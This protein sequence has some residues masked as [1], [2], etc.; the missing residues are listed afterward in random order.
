[1]LNRR[2][3]LPIGAAGLIAGLPTFFIVCDY[4]HIEKTKFVTASF[5]AVWVTTG[6]IGGLG[7]RTALLK[8]PLITLA[9]LQFFIISFANWVAWDKGSEQD[10][11]MWA[12]CVPGAIAPLLFASKFDRQALRTFF[13]A[14]IGWGSLLAVLVLAGYVANVDLGIEV[15]RFNVA[16]A[17]NPITQSLV[18]GFAVI[19]LYAKAL[20]QGTYYILA[21]ILVMIFSMLLAGSRGPAIAIVAAMLLMTLMLQWSVR[22][23]LII[24][25]VAASVAVVITYLPQSVFGRYFSEDVWLDTKTGQGVQTRIDLYTTGL[26]TW[27]KHPVFGSGTSG[28]AHLISYTHNL[29]IQILMET[30][31]VG[32]LLFLSASL[33]LAFNFFKRSRLEAQSSWETLAFAGFLVYS[34]IESQVSG[35][36]IRLD[37]LWVCMGV[38]ISWPRIISAQNQIDIPARISPMRAVFQPSALRQMRAVIVTEKMCAK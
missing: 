32:L 6:I 4:L 9:L 36:Y 30:G 22:Q 11:L 38:L 28:N 37:F 3:L 2:L 23:I 35:T 21:L 27:L 20:V 8:R 19:A 13:I 1:M 34:V 25:F 18:I 26:Q 15:S 5:I 17:L 7:R 24:L 33:P 31:A 16:E 14:I 29:F 10:E 12:Y